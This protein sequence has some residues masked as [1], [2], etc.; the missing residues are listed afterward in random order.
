MRSAVEHKRRKNNDERATREQE[1]AGDPRVGRGK[2]SRFTEVRV[3]ECPFGY[4]RRR[5]ACEE[6][7]ITRARFVPEM[8]FEVSYTSNCLI[9]STPWGSRDETCVARS[10][11]GH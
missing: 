1:K 11:P 9:N 2:Q 5:Q 4:K 6:A 7:A 3:N 8:R 10:V